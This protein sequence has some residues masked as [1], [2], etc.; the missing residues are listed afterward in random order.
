MRWKD[1]RNDKGFMNI[2]DHIKNIIID[3]CTHVHMY[4]CMYDFYMKKVSLTHA[5]WYVGDVHVS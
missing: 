3:T 5:I 4:T 1:M 2:Y